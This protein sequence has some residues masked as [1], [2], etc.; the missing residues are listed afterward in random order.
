MRR[1]LAIFV[2]RNK[3]F[4]RDRAAFGWNFIFPLLII[5]GFALMFQ[6][7]GQT[8][9]K[10]GVIPASDGAA[11]CAGVPDTVAAQPLFDAVVLDSR[12]DGFEKLQRHRLDMVVTCTGRPPVAYW[13]NE[14]SPKGK[15]AESLLVTAL[16]GPETREGLVVRETVSGRQIRYI[17]W[18]FPGIIAMNAMFSALFGV[19][20][21]V[22]RYR[23]SG[24]LKRF[25]ATPL[26]PLEYLGAQVASRMLVLMSTNVIV[27]AGC[28]LLL[29]FRC[30][31]S[32]VDLIVL[33]A[34]GCASLI[35]LGLIIAAR[36]SSEE[37]ANGVL[38]FIAWPMMFLSEVWFSLEGAAPW[39]RKLAQLF[40]LTHVTEGM[41]RIMNDGASLADLG[42]H[43]AVLGAMTVVVH[44]RRLA[45]VQ[46]DRLSGRTMPR[47][48][49]G[50]VDR[51]GRLP[52]TC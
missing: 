1:F 20:W 30:Q 40:P 34:L 32:Y 27:Y 6:R 2:A 51:A 17:D 41:R 35:A 43:L 14:S 31:G 49:G 39:V 4:Y 5:L 37:F 45:D 21:V 3:E 19:G 24:V 33:F 18:L 13:V 10:V 50:P 46:V 36:S 8:P 22:V 16:V 7:G 9:Y 42:Y 25:K 47:T 23:K 15:I 26:T 48:H 28:A 11:P 29:G 44:G 12:A 38:N 52:R